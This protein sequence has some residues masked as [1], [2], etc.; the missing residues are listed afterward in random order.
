MVEHTCSVCSSKE[1][2]GIKT[3]TVLK[4]PI[5]RNNSVSSQWSTALPSKL[6]IPR[7]TR[8]YISAP[9]IRLSSE[10][11]LSLPMLSLRLSSHLAS[12]SLLELPSSSMWKEP[13]MHSNLERRHPS[14]RQDCH[15]EVS[16]TSPSFAES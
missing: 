3:P 6:P 12:G 7:M 10:E 1:P 13:P 15:E 16:H 11:T 8:V 9:C 2:S 14:E 5:P 4:S